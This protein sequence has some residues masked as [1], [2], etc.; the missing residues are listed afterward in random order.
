M[1]MSMAEKLNLKGQEMQVLNAPEGY[2]TDLAAELP[3]VTLA[4]MGEGVADAVLVFVKD[5]EE[6]GRLAPTA[7]R[8]VRPGGLLW[9]AYP[10]GTSKIKS[11]VNRDRLWPVLEA[12]G[13]RPV[14]QVVLDDVRSAMRFRPVDEVGR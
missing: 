14:R 8:R 3:G 12:I 4:T 1:A 5:L 7:A 13:W 11:D 10:K 2:L 6:A 9:V